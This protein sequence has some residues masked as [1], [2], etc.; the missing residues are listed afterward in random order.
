MDLCFHFLLNPLLNFRSYALLNL[1]QQPLLLLLLYHNTCFRFRFRYTSC[2]LNGSGTGL[3]ITSIS[4]FYTSSVAISFDITNVLVVP[5]LGS[6]DSG[7]SANNSI[8]TLFGLSKSS[9]EIRFCFLVTADLDPT[10]VFRIMNQSPLFLS[11]SFF[12][13]DFAPKI[14]FLRHWANICKGQCHQIPFSRREIVSL[15]ISNNTWII[16]LFLYSFIPLFR[17]RIVLS[18]ASPYSGNQHLYIA[19]VIWA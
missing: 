8:G 9:S 15:R 4:W 1:W 16:P 18:G 14:S 13:S 6:A 19:M 2:Y 17:P 12:G 3:G 10:G 11:S 7:S 5:S